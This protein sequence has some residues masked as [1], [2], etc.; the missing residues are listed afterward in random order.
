MEVVTEVVAWKR[1]P[2]E[3][4]ELNAAASGPAAWPP[5]ARA[6]PAQPVSWLVRDVTATNKAQGAASGIPSQQHSKP[7]PAVQVLVALLLSVSCL[8]QA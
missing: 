6:V 2:K 8:L 1:V 7:S 4:R 3:R 5:L